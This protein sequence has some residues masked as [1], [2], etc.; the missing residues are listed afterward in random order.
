MLV[1]PVV[2]PFRFDP[3]NWRLT[4]FVVTHDHLDHLDPETVQ[5]YRFQSE[6]QFV[7]PRLAC[8]KLRD[9]GVP[10][11]NIVR[12]DSGESAVVNDVKITG[13]Y[14]LP[15]APEAVDT[16][17]YKIEF[18]N[19]RSLYFTSDTGFSDLLLSCAPSAEVLLA[20]INGKWGNLNAEQ[21]AKLALK[22]S[23][24]YA[25]PNHYDM[26]C[27]NSENPKIFEYFIDQL[28]TQIQTRIL[29]I[30]EPFVWPQGI[31]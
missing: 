26:M 31:L 15:T 25:I 6:T 11:A 18:S 23:P 21:A 12:L 1:S 20:C 3:K 8:K 9:L 19:H 2:F 5:R 7:A 27:L 30:M 22:V 14:A 4:F 17:G 16:T 24:L 29:K 10:D 28:K 13:I